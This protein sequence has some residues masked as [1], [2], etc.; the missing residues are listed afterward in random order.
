MLFLP[1]FFLSMFYVVFIRRYCEEH[2]MKTYNRSVSHSLKALFF[3]GLV[4]CLFK[5]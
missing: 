2:F 1:Y 3:V 5:P 4:V